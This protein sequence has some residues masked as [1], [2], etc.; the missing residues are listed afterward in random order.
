MPA[1]KTHGGIVGRGG[2]RIAPLASL[3]APPQ[4]LTFDSP[5]RGTAMN[6]VWIFLRLKEAGEELTRT[7]QE[8]EEDPKYDFGEYFVAMMHLYHHL[9]AAWN[10]RDATPDRVKSCTFEGIREVATISDASRPVR[11]LI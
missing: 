3:L 4:T 7:I 11:N 6:R 9:N 1:T 2:K 5:F 10:S 8:M